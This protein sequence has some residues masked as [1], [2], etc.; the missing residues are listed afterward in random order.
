M[1]RISKTYRLREEYKAEFYKRVLL[2]ANRFNHAHFLQD[3]QFE[4]YPYGGFRTIVAAGADEKDIFRTD[5][6]GNTFEKLQQFYDS[7]KDWLF[8]YFAYDLKN[9]TENLQSQHPNH[10]EFPTCYFYVP[11]H[12]IFIEND[13]FTIESPQEP[14]ELYHTIF[15]LRHDLVLSDNQT[16]LLEELQARV[17]REDYISNVKKIKDH[18][19]EGDIY[20]L[21]YCIEFFSGKASIQPTEVYQALNKLSPMPFS[22]FV[23][24][25]SGKYLMCASPERFL[26]KQGNQ[27]ISQPIKGTIRRGKTNEEDN[28]LREE[29]RNSEKEQAENMMIVDL[30]RNDLNRSAKTGSVKVEEIFGIY[31]FRALHQMISTVTAQIRDNMSFTTVI[32]NAFP[33][34]SMTG[35]PKIKAMQLIDQYEAN[36]R[37][38]YSGAVGYI[39]PE[40]DFDFNVVIR[41]ILYNS[42]KKYLSFSVGSAIT[43]DADPAQE[44]EECLL[45]AET[46]KRVLTSTAYQFPK[47]NKNLLP[48]EILK[49]VFGVVF[50]TFFISNVIS[51]QWR[52]IN[53]A[54]LPVAGIISLLQVLCYTGFKLIP[55]R[56]SRGWNILHNWVAHLLNGPFALCYAVIAWILMGLAAFY[57]I[58]YSF[59]LKFFE[60]KFD[61]EEFNKEFQKTDPIVPPIEYMEKAN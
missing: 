39:T 18:I 16:V 46:M 60:K 8:G 38:L 3:N 21:N 26:K 17:N 6:E 35:A 14:D 19:L 50:Y 47:I 4:N 37:G 31:T 51:G 11:Q 45:K 20:E 52:L 54:T 22:A 42:E 30:V 56:K 7:K 33:M 55:Y 10:P 44:Y 34:G 36:S 48:E 23:K 29:L 25:K 12:L 58:F 43:Y 53:S 59:Y 9:E 61:M 1:K 5:E 57:G 49:L 2:W 13:C 15:S 24:V 27:L 28:Q 41:S 40:S 32:K